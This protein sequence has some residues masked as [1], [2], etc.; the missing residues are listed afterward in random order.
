VKN[1]GLAQSYPCFGTNTPRTS[2]SFH[3]GYGSIQKLFKTHEHDSSSAPNKSIHSV[4]HCRIYHSW[5]VA[6]PRPRPGSTHHKRT[7]SRWPASIRSIPTLSFTATSTTG[8]TNVTVT[9]SASTLLGG[10]YL[11]I[12]Y[13]PLSGLTIGGASTAETVSAPLSPN[14]VYSATIVVSDTKGSTTQ[15]VGYFD[16]LSPVYTWEAEDWD[17]T[18]SAGA[19]GQFFDNPQTNK[20]AGLGALGGTDFLM[21][22]PNNGTESYRPQDIVVPGVSTNSLGLETQAT[23][24]LARLPWFGSS[25]YVG[26]DY[27]IGYT[28]SG[29]FANYTR[30]YPSSA[31]QPAG[32]F[33]VYARFADGAGNN[34][35]A[36]TLS[37]SSTA[38]ATQL[39]GTPPF[40]FSDKLTGWSSYAF[41]A[42]RDS[43]GALVQMQSDGSETTLNLFVNSG[44]FNANYFMLMP[45]DTNLASS[46]LYTNMYPDGATQFQP[47]SNLTFTIVDTAGVV[48]NAVTVV[49][50]GTN[51]LGQVTNA[52]VRTANGLTASGPD[53]ALI[54]SVP[55]ASNTTY[56]VLVGASDLTGNQST[57]TWSFDTISPVY[58]WEAMDFD[59]SS[60]GGS[61]ML[62]NLF[63]D[64]GEPDHFNLIAHSKDRGRWRMT[65]DFG[66][67]PESP[68]SAGRQTQRHVLFPFGHG[69]AGI[70]LDI[71]VIIADIR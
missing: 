71:I 40:T 69:A 48:S 17:Y 3:L 62:N 65:V 12:T 19:S 15:T 43:T 33:N 5:H 16:T 42:L 28:D 10:S 7:L 9:L 68:P 8:V 67:L 20:Y 52:T 44:S 29:D 53:T 22:N 66:I 36:A 70:I 4:L 51:I 2:W 59:Y 32:A 47:S 21:E 38:G 6:M 41:Y 27:E 26:Q 13:T 35:V 24:D 63:I 34:T 60:N 31:A 54:V 18:N 50:S 45:A 11:P 57:T 56:S 14:T 23:A 58:T 55:L 39:I 1:D 61:G 49:L 37:V 25:P 64:I 30:H 46:T